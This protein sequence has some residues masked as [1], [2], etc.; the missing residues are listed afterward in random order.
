MDFSLTSVRCCTLLLLH[1]YACCFLDIAT[2]LLH[3]LGHSPD[4]APPFRTSTGICFNLFLLVQS[5]EL[6]RTPSSALWADCLLLILISWWR[7]RRCRHYLPTPRAWPDFFPNTSSI[8]P[9]T[10]GTYLPSVQARPGLWTS[11]SC[12]SCILFLRICPSACF[13]PQHLRWLHLQT[14]R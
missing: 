5:L 12:S 4:E 3:R 10:S 8:A 6:L 1:D 2:C 14:S 11:D 7:D 9:R 13:R